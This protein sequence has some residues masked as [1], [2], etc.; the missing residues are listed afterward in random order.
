MSKRRFVQAV[1]VRK[2]PAV[3][4]LPEVVVYAEQLWNGLTQRGYGA[5]SGK[6]PRVSDDWLAKLNPAQREAFDVFWNAF[7]HKHDRNGAAM[8]WHQLGVLSR[9]E[10]Q[11]IIS[12]ARAE[13]GRVLQPGQVRKMAQGWLFEKRWLDHAAK[14]AV[15]AKAGAAVEYNN[16]S[17]ELV[18]LRSLFESSGDPAL[19]GQIAALEAKLKFVRDAQGGVDAT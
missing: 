16:L 14:P 8:R 1:V 6:E 17:R 3:E 15:D 19:A 9:A 5:E 7:A 2:L 18:G 11:V 12:A 10:Y 4:Q 13:A